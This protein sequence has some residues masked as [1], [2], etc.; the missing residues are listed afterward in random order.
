[1][2]G[3]RQ[4]DLVIRFDEAHRTDIGDIRSATV[5]LPG[6]SQ[7]PL[8][9][10]AEITYTQGPAKIS[11]D[12]T[13]RRIVV[14]VNVRGRDL[15]SVVKDVQDI[16][17]REI[18]LPVG[19]S[20]TYGG[21]FENLR[22]AR[23]RLSVA[24]PI[25]LI[26]IF[27]LLYFAFDSVKEALMIYSAIP[28]ASVGGV[29]LLYLRD[30]PFSI[31]AG[32]GF[33]ALFGIAVLNGIVLI[34]HFKELKAQGMS[35]I[36]RRILIGTRD[37]LRP[38]LLTAAAAALG[39]LPMAISSSA[40]AEVQR[41]LAT[42]VIGGLISS[43]ALTL[44]VLP[45]LYA[46][47][48]RKGKNPQKTVQPQ[49]LAVLLIGLVCLPAAAQ[50]QAPAE[51]LTVEHAMDLAVKHNARLKAASLQVERSR[52]VLGTSFDPE[53]TQVYY[54]F[55]QNNIA[56]NGLPIHVWGINQTLRFPTVY[57]AQ[58]KLNEA[59]VHVQEQQYRLD[60]QYL[61]KEVSKAYYEVV[62]WQH[63]QTNY[64]YLDSL[65]GQLAHAATRRFELGETN[66][67]EQLTA[68]TRRKE[69]QLLLKQAEESSIRAREQL[70]KW[71]QTSDSLRIEAQSLPRL[72]WEEVDTLDHPGIRYAAASVNVAADAIKLEKQKL[73]PDLSLGYFRG[74]NQGPNP[75]AYNGVQAGIAVPLWFGAQ[76]A[77][78]RASQT[79]YLAVR[80]EA[81]DYRTQLL[82]RYRELR[83]ELRKY[84]KA[85]TFYEESGQRLARELRQTAGTAFQ[86]GE[87]DFFRYAQSLDQARAI[88][89][90]YLENLLRYD[91]IVLEINFLMN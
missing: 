2:R 20:I 81:N 77:S 67:L 16:I 87:I 15:E 82:A 35:D 86:N 13:K 17:A 37:R 60:E 66:Y 4:F 59:R 63:V 3:E 80:E 68:E 74:T 8:S 89:I 24:V 34:E 79:E 45:V 61:K 10:F 41:P 58:R 75:R 90:N 6:G 32:V 78:V 18:T 42:V 12:D 25:A 91:Q 62:Y 26:L 1:L 36:N 14:G 44:V 7:M 88:E 71:M 39:F 23:A 51:P 47:F 84:E 21:Q 65:Y 57:G 69:T 53:K 46:L 11:R 52:Q 56:E 5:S 49:H 38:V 9:E 70:R 76:K 48:D 64:H 33:I 22:S 31:S 30:M 55:D 43:T 19:Y 27:V 54:S 50:S 28:L 73:L 85:L 83:S 40:G 29:L 72:V